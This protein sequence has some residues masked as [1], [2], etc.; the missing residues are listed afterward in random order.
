M[1]NFYKPFIKDYEIAQNE[2]EKVQHKGTGELCPICG[3]EL[4]YK[5]GKNG[6][7]IGCS[8]FP[9]CRYIKKEQKPEE[10]LKYTG[11]NC[12]DCGKP[13]IIRK[14]R[15]GREFIGCSGFPNCHY[16]KVEQ[17]ENA[18][19]IK[20]N[21]VVGTCP[22]CGNNLIKKKGKYSYFIGCSNF[23]KCNYMEKIKRKK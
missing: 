12:P 17:K 20:E 6:Q 23:P 16:I 11:E 8:N 1:N 14:D 15:K 3:S 13:L 2:L 10:E 5:D 18:K 9:K 19:P 4:V 21:E 7:F 22:K